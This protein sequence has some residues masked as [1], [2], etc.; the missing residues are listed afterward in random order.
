[1]ADV[2]WAHN[3][4]QKPFYVICK[5][6]FSPLWRTKSLLLLLVP[7]HSLHLTF[8]NKIEPTRKKKKQKKT[9]IHLPTKSIFH[10]CLDLLYLPFC[11]R[12]DLSPFLAKANLPTYRI[13]PLHY[14]K[15]LLLKISYLLFLLHH[16]TK[17]SNP[18]KKALLISPLT[19]L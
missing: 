5:F 12:D 14:S 3:T 18:W 4:A 10:I 17:Q 6:E 1:M 19:T 2:K 11:P 13:H 15:I 9:M 16:K 7:S 8:T